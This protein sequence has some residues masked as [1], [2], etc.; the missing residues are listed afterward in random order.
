MLNVAYSVVAG[1]TVAG[2]LAYLFSGRNDQAAK[3][4]QLIQRINTMI[5]NKMGSLASFLEKDFGTPPNAIER[6]AAHSYWVRVFIYE[7]QIPGDTQKL[8]ETLS[9]D[10]RKLALAYLSAVDQGREFSKSKYPEHFERVKGFAEEFLK[11]AD[12]AEKAHYAAMQAPTPSSLIEGNRVRPIDAHE[13]I[14][15]GP[16][17]RRHP[18]T[19]LM[20]AEFRRDQFPRAQKGVDFH[21][22]SF[23]MQSRPKV[24]ESMK[25]GPKT[26]TEEGSVTVTAYERPVQVEFYPTRKMTKEPSYLNDIQGAGALTTQAMVT[27]YR[28]EDGTTAYMVRYKDY[29]ASPVAEKY[30]VSKVIP[31][32]DA[33]EEYE[34]EL[35]LETAQAKIMEFSKE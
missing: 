30:L 26:V 2:G 1:V 27:E 33:G 7:T 14:N 12:E 25:Q 17:F 19:A 8:I 11:E 4:K 35:D 31:I 6:E 9:D 16:K 23:N 24:I 28:F 5:Q 32:G 3:D 18:V 20:L 22:H 10:E 29:K 34:A 15:L 13:R 21:F